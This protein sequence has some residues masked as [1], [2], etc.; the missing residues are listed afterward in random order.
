MLKSFKKEYQTA[1]VEGKVKSTE[2]K[3]NLKWSGFR[4]LAFKFMTYVPSFT[5]STNAAGKK[6]AIHVGTFLMATMGWLFHLLSWNLIARSKTVDNINASQISWSG[7]HM[8]IDILASK[9]DQAGEKTAGPRGVF[10]NPLDPSICA[11]LAFAVFFFSWPHW[12]GGKLF[13]GS[14]QNS[15][16][17]DMLRIMLATLTML[18]LALLGDFVK[19][20][21]TH[22]ERKG[23]ASFVLG[24]LNGPSTIAVYLRALWSLGNTQNRYL[25][26]SDATDCQVGRCAA[27]L[28]TDHADFMVLPPH[29]KKEDE[30]GVYN[31]LRTL[32]NWDKY[33]KS[34]QQVVPYLF[35]SLVYHEPYLRGVLPSNHP[36]WSSTII[37]TNQV[38]IRI[39]TVL[40]GNNH[41]PSTGMKAD[42]VPALNILLGKMVEVQA[43]STRVE[44]AMQDLIRTLPQQFD[45]FSDTVVEKIGENVRV[46]GMVP[47]TKQFVV[48]SLKSALDSFQLQLRADFTAL[49]RVTTDAGGQ[50]AAPPIVAGVGAGRPPYNRYQWANPRTD[51]R[52]P[53]DHPIKQT[54]EW[55]KSK[56]ADM[57]VL[58][59][60]GDESLNIGPYKF[61]HETDMVDAS[62]LSMRSRV[63]K[64]MQHFVNS[65]RA[66]NAG[67]DNMERR[68]KI[69]AFR[70]AYSGTVDALY[71]GGAKRTKAIDA[72]TFSTYYEKICHL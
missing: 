50:A 40:T 32:P 23:A 46:E 56:V 9:K 70:A 10:A 30:E 51:S 8:V 41:C 66:K 31:L 4:M 62:K 27:G 61:I 52:Q 58:W 1:R 3:R 2:G 42:G 19:D 11:I 63:V 34:F 49:G 26:Q 67:F 60:Y 44:V 21:G 35:A 59:E 39:G 15:R 64:V 45:K 29:F 33:P 36:L 13:E 68:D 65:A 5:T 7:D 17:S 6:R 43:Q 37:T 20:I 71:S 18:E 54:F 69:T 12:E 14:E 47:L 48:D 25:F 28:P 24:L 16:F 53:T 22:S 57:F 55:P 38:G 72:I